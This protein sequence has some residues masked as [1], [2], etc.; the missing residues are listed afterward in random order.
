MKDLLA[1]IGAL[2]LMGLAIGFVSKIVWWAIIG[3]GIYLGY[4]LLIANNDNKQIK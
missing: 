3:G 1:I 2:L 4:K